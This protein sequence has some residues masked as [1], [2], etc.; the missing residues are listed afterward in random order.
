MTI[1][2]YE[3]EADF[4]DAD[5]IEKIESGIDTL[6]KEAEKLKE[7]EKD[8]TITTAEG[9]RRQCKV[10]KDFFDYVFGEGTSEKIFKGKNS[11]NLCLKAYE[12]IVEAR[13]NQFNELNKRVDAYSPDRLKR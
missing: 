10:L 13:D 9:I 11:L 2:G 12:D 6:Y 7:L 4:T 3:L 8:K 5:L 1:N